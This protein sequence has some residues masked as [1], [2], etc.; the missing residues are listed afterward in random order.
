MFRYAIAR[1][2]AG[3]YISPLLDLDDY[4]GRAFGGPQTKRLSWRA[5]NRSAG[6][7]LGNAVRS[8]ARRGGYGRW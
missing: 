2:P 4:P 3:R 5:C 8:A 6:A 7:R 1:N